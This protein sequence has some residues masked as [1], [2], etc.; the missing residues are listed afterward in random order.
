MKKVLLDTNIIVYRESDNVRKENI[1]LLYNIIDNDVDMVKFIHPIIKKEL[2]QNIYDE[3][4]RILLERLKSY[5]MLE[6]TSSRFGDQF[7]QKVSFLNKDIN[8][9]LDDVILNEVY[10]NNVD[11]LITEDKKMK[12]KSVLLNIQDRVMNM[13]EFIYINKKEK[14][15]NHD[16]LDI[17]KKKMGSLD[18]NDE[19][20]KDLKKN[21]PGF[22]SWFH[23]KK[24]EDAYCYM[25][26]DNLLALLFLKNEE[27][28]DDDYQDIIPTMKINRKLKISTFKV[29]VQ[30]KKI[31]ERF[32]KIIFDQARFSMVDEIY[33][34]IYDNDDKKRKLISYFETFGFKYHGKKNG[35]ELVYVR[36]MTKNF[37]SDNPLQTYP[38]IKNTNDSYLIAINPN[39]HTFLLPDSILYKESYKDIH[40][41]VE[42]AIRKYYIS[43]AGFLEKPKIGDNIVFYRTKQEPI[44]AKY[45]SV[46]TTI[47]LVTNVIIPRN[48]LHLCEL[49]KNKSVYTEKEL[50]SKY[51]KNTYVIEFVYITTLPQKLN[52]NI[53][54]IND[55]FEAAPR[56]VEKI[57]TKQFQ[58]ILELGEVDSYFII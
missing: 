5:N 39:Y 47:G 4:R 57:D 28:G 14:K 43:Q 18:I 21:Y 48:S 53:C 23:R 13:K 27:I 24:D 38:Y 17:Y 32:M 3:K 26:G 10:N 54:V 7:K 50:S 19:F 33:V 30:H 52:N 25:E 8:D 51:T 2:L 36:N 55:I 41:P 44:P 40:M 35:K 16:I 45:S 9:E 46:L 20:F 12:R 49:V 37:N 29:D 22:E 11:L 42:Y 58:K 34:T 31:G 6:R 15:V 56:S 1:G